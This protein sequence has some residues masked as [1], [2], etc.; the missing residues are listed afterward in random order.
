MDVSVSGN[1]NWIGGSKSESGGSIHGENCA[2]AR[3]HVS[4]ASIGSFINGGSDSDAGG[5]RTPGADS[6]NSDESSYYRPASRGGTRSDFVTTASAP[7]S[8]P[9]PGPSV[10]VAAAAA[11]RTHAALAAES[12][13]SASNASIGGVNGGSSQNVR[14]GRRK[15]RMKK[16][17]CDVS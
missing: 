15:R 6:M 7:L 1:G 12:T 8:K 4:M 2:S 5:T 11:R 14:T 16:D 10:A 3:S 17:S 9:P 13:W